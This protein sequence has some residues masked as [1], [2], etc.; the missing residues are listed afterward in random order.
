MSLW[1][2]ILD[3]FGFVFDTKFFSLLPSRYNRQ[4]RRLSEEGLGYSLGRNPPRLL[5]QSKAYAY[6]P[7]TTPLQDVVSSFTRHYF[8]QIFLY[9]LPIRFQFIPSFLEM[10]MGRQRALVRQVIATLKQQEKG[11]SSTSASK[12]VTKGTL[13]RKKEGKDDHPQKRRQALL[14]P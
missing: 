6:S 13:K 5:W 1:L 14:S 12:V 8:Y 10:E 4:V 11:G 7:M 9:T 2:F 3:N